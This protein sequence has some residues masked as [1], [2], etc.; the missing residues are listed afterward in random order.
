M[1]MKTGKGGKKEMSLLA[2]AFSV[3]ISG[4]TDGEQAR[5]QGLPTYHVQTPTIPSCI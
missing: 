2:M 4:I 3:I 5:R 1:C